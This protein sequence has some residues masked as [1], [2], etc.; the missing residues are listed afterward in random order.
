MS[1]LKSFERAL[2][3]GFLAATDRPF[4]GDFVTVPRDALALGDAP[5]IL[6]LR[7]DRIGDVLVSVPVI[8]A[9]RHR[10]P[11]ARL[12]MLFSRTNFGVRQAVQPYVDHA[13]R[14]DKTLA[15]AVRL[16]WALRRP[17]SG[18]RASG[19]HRP[20]PALRDQHLGAV[21]GPGQLHR[22]YPLDAA[23]RSQI[24]DLG[25]WRA[26]SPGRGRRHHRRDGRRRHSPPGIVSRFRR[27]RAGV[28]PTA[29]ARYVGH[30]PRRGVED[31]HDRPVPH[32]P[33]GAAALV[34]LSHC[35][36]RPDPPCRRGAHSARRRAGRDP[37][38][39]SRAVSTKRG[40]Y[41]LATRA[42]Q[43]DGSTSPCGTVARN[44]W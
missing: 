37:L 35:L 24:R 34:P 18:S 15:G 44:S 25:G 8:R 39:R 27:H 20:A 2:R 19:S 13:W 9:L 23:V 28:R 29:D 10:Y 4:T 3:R 12:D 40:G 33:R 6:L 11:D 32:A 26:G 36:P 31:P 14:Y 42:A 41:A 43:S 17:R 30:P 21:L 5:R 1:A 7:Q 22:V 38:A 16:L